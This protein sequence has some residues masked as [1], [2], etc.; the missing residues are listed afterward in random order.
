MPSL[1]P[2]L[3][4][5][6]RTLPRALPHSLNNVLA[7]ASQS[8]QKPNNRPGR[9]GWVPCVTI[10]GKLYHRLGPLEADDASTP[11]FAQ[12]YIHDPAVDDTELEQRYDSLHFNA[13]VS[14]GEKDRVLDLLGTLQESLRAENAYVSDFIAAGE[15]FAADGADAAELIISRDARPAGE[16]ERRY[17]PATGGAPRT[18]QEVTVLMGEGG[19]EDER[20]CIHLRHR[21]IPDGTRWRRHASAPTGTIPLRHHELEKALAAAKVAQFN[22][23]QY[24]Q[25]DGFAEL[26]VH[27][28]ECASVVRAGASYFTPTGALKSIAHGHRAHDPL[29]FVLLFPRGDDGYSYYLKRAHPSNGD[30]GNG[31]GDDGHGDE[32]NGDG[33]DEQCH[34]SEWSAASDCDWSDCGANDEYCTCCQEKWNIKR[35]CHLCPHIHT[36]V[37]F[38]LRRFLRARRPSS[39]DGDQST[40]SQQPVEAPENLTSQKPL[41]AM[42]AAHLPLRAMTA[43]HPPLR[44]MGAAHP[45]LRAMGAVRQRLRI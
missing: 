20:Q 4:A 19:V 32:G 1:T 26:G 30:E 21:H 5:S 25:L 31:D 11:Q 36:D 35:A 8:V 2:C 44:A 24:V 18:F 45:P 38:E 39:A 27:G 33:D 10:Q 22:G 9:S 14:R 40:P 13:N 6:T 42:G 7:L 23:N 3:T 28:L 43:A 37:S 17:D 41:R 29:H 16:H 12:L 15:L 34:E